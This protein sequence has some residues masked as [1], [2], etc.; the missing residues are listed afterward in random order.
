M[1]V[2]IVESRSDL[3]ELW[4][5]HLVR[6]GTTVS[7]VATQ[8]AATTFLA[9][10][11]VDIIILDLV[12]SEVSAL[13]VADYANYRQPE[14][15]VLFVTS[16]SFFSDGSIFAHSGNARAFLPA[17]TPPEDIAAMVE[18]FGSERQRGTAQV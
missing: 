5:Q 13:A 7:R 12:L 3:G 8:D 17:G 10:T 16:T 11:D 4:E 18:H 9:E 15:R 2:L 6:Q 14:A 1:H